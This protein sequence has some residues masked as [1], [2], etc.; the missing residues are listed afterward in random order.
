MMARISVMAL[1]SLLFLV[2]SSVGEGTLLLTMTENVWVHEKGD[3]EYGDC[4]IRC[5]SCYFYQSPVVDAIILV[6]NY[7]CV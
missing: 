2:S 4:K 7:I 3:N 5:D 1:T 6:K